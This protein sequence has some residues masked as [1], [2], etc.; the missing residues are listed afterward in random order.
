MR[1]PPGVWC[2]WCRRVSSCGGGGPGRDPAV[3]TVLVLA[4]LAYSYER[5]AQSSQWL[6]AGLGAG[7]SERWLARVHFDVGRLHQHVATPKPV[8]QQLLS[9]LEHSAYEPQ[10]KPGSTICCCQSVSSLPLVAFAEPPSPRTPIPQPWQVD[11]VIFISPPRS[12]PPV[13]TS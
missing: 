9:L 4:R 3:Q 6:P 5:Q 1:R 7:T 12:L 11:N 8:R 2:R 10:F 13:T